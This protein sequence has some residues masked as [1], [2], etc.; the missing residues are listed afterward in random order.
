[1]TGCSMTP[2]SIVKTRYS[3]AGF[4]AEYETIFQNNTHAVVVARKPQDGCI[5]VETIALS[6]MNVSR[7]WRIIRSQSDIDCPKSKAVVN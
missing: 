1:M 4:N 6:T 3:N 5:V 2:L 7:D